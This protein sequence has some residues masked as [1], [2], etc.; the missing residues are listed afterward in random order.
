VEERPEGDGRKRGLARTPNPIPHHHDTR[1]ELA[2]LAH[3]SE[4]KIH[5]RGVVYAFL[6]PSS[7]VLRRLQ[8]FCSMQQTPG[9]RNVEWRPVG[10]LLHNTETPTVQ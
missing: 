2:D 6:R 8:G 9:L 5:L 4:H 7:A 10:G 1:K 3:V